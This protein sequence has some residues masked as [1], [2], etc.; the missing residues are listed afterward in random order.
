MESGVTVEHGG[1]SLTTCLEAEAS[2]RKP[3][4]S[5]VKIARRE[6]ISRDQLVQVCRVC[7]EAKGV[8]SGTSLHTGNREQGT[9]DKLDRDD[10]ASR[11]SV[12][13]GRDKS[14]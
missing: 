2:T 14:N 12:N 13:E 1:I 4:N 5:S 3:A 7:L 9:H 8:P 6:S 10:Q 11:V